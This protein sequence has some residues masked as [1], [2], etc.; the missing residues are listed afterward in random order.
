MRHPDCYARLHNLWSKKH[1]TPFQWGKHD[2]LALALE[3][4]KAVTGETLSSSPQPLPYNS[5]K[6]ARQ[7]LKQQPFL[8]RV[9]HALKRFERVENYASLQS[10]DLAVVAMPTLSMQA[11]MLFS[12]HDRQ[13]ENWLA[14][15]TLDLCASGFVLPRLPV[16]ITRINKRYLTIVKAWRIA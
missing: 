11:S 5:Y 7:L 16:G 4:V 2:C 10:G 13:E 8:N 6:S 9:E 15:A 3:A 1:N 14:L 12:A